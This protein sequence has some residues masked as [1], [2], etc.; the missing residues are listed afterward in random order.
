M[1][2]VFLFIGFFI[3]FSLF[4]LVYI[5]A[6]TVLFPSQLGTWFWVVATYQLGPRLEVFHENT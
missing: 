6:Y 5:P 3:F 1:G 2:D 4:A